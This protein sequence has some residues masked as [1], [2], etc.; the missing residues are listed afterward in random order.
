MI[1][2]VGAVALLFLFAGFVLGWI[3]RGLFSKKDK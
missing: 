1:Y 3:M 2:E